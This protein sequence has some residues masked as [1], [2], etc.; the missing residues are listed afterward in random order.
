MTSSKTTKLGTSALA[1]AAAL[2]ALA[3]VNH[4]VARR[5][6]RRHPPGGRFIT[7]DGVRLHV[8]DR[9][10]GPAVVLIHGN[11]V[12]GDDWDISG[13][14]DLLLQKHRVI[15]FDRPGF[16]YSERPRGR[17]WTAA[18]QAGLILGA[19]R[20]MGV[21]QP[22]IVGH[23]WGAMVALNLAVRAQG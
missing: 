17:A 20:Q 13:V 11:A 15:I 12:A 8:M 5:T 23:S 19:L 18:R 9:G 14:A 21:E 10:K 22:S 7:V 6:E 2:A 16:G 4:L 3:A 1:C